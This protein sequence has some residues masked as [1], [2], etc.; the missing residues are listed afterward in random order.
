MKGSVWR[1]DLLMKGRLENRHTVVP[2]QKLKVSEK[3]FSAFR[4]L[5]DSSVTSHLLNRSL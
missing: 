2:D 3:I 4:L 5:Y 1:L